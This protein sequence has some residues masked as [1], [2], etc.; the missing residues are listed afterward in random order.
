MADMT[1][2]EI[3]AE[4]GRRLVDAI[5]VLE[6]PGVAEALGLLFDYID[7]RAAAR[8]PFIGERGAM[9]MFRT[10]VR[11]NA[12]ALRMVASWGDG[13]CGALHD[14][15]RKELQ[16]WEP[17]RAGPLFAEDGGVSP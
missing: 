6:R 8:V 13:E 17:R 11:E 4:I 16:G 10:F 15:L 2:S 5:C 12:E 1:E 3:R 7:A 9:E 14:V